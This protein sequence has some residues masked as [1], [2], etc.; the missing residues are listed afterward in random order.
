MGRKPDN[1]ACGRKREQGSCFTINELR[2]VAAEIRRARGVRVPGSTKAELLEGVMDALAC[3]GDRCLT[4]SMDLPLPLRR[5]LREALVPLAPRDWV[6]N[7]TAWLSNVDIELK[8]QELVRRRRQYD[9]LGVFPMDAEHRQRGEPRCV[10]P[11]L[12][13]YHPVEARRGKR[14]CFAAVFNTDY[15]GMPGSHWVALVGYIRRGDPRYGLYYYDSTGR[16]PT[17]DINDIITRLSREL[18]EADGV[19]PPYMY[20]DTRHQSSNTE[21]GMFCISFID[22]M[23]NTRRTFPEMCQRMQDDAEMIRRRSRYFEIPDASA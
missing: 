16:A 11:S 6:D 8:V 15:H 17:G 18:K 23:V 19:E 22:A 12:C 3:R 2:A 14:H 21:C 20:N 7:P 1:C 4:Q 5:R 9:F 13:N 10:S